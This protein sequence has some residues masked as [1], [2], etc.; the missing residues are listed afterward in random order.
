MKIEIKNPEYIKVVEEECAECDRIISKML[1]FACLKARINHNAV[2]NANVVYENLAT[3]NVTKEQ[4]R[5]LRKMT[6]KRVKE[7]VMDD[8][9]QGID[10]EFM[11]SV[12]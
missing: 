9:K 7:L 3:L 11:F 6:N 2:I 12:K 4:A 10:V 1:E 8:I 5:T